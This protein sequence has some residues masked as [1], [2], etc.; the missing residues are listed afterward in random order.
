MVYCLLQVVVT[1]YSDKLNV[2]L[3]KIVERMTTL[4]IEPVKFEMYLDMV[5]KYIRTY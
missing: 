4:E 3:M 1:G 2:L 5:G